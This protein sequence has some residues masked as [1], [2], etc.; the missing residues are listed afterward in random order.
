MKLYTF[1]IVILM[2]FSVT[3]S[4]FYASENQLKETEGRITG[5]V[6]LTPKN[7]P[8]RFLGAMYGRPTSSPPETVT[9]S[10]LVVLLGSQSSTTSKNTG[11]VILDQKDQKFIPN[12]LPI[13]QNQ[14]VRIHNSDPV[15]HNVFSLSKTKK[16]DVGRR[17]KGEYLDVTFDKPGVVDVFC[18]I[19]SNMHAVI[20]V[21]PTNALY[22]LKVKSGETF[23]LD[24]VPPGNYE[25]KLFASGYKEQSVAVEVES[26]KITQIGTVTL[27]L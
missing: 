24:E 5:V 26:G 11:P 10:V 22:W 7:T 6:K 21:I 20:Y 18:D 3:A 25:L 23:N 19:H 15:Y 9:D 12:L 13:R 2:S 1:T 16:F 8:A 17:P 4:Q 27:N 14:D